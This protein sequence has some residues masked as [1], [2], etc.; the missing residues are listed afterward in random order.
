MK[1]VIFGAKCSPTLANF[2]LRK[3]AEDHVTGTTESL[4]AAKAITKN[5]YMDDFLKSEESV[6]DA[7]T[8]QREVTSLVAKG[9]FRLTKWMSNSPD[10]LRSV[11]LEERSSCE[12]D[13]SCLGQAE[14]RALG[15]FWS[16]AE[17]FLCVKSSEVD[18]TASK[19]GVLRRLSMVFDPLGIVSPFLLRAKLLVQRLWALRCGWDEPLTG[20][21]LTVWGQWLSELPL[22]RDIK[23]P[24]CLKSELPLGAAVHAVELHVFCDASENAFGAV[25]YMR[26]ITQEGEVSTSFVMSRTR[27]APLKQLT[28][29][30]LE[31]Q[32]AVLGVRLVNFIKQ[33]LSYTVSNTFYWTDSQV[34][35]KYINSESRRYQTF[36]ANRIAEIHES[37]HP[38]QWRHV[39]GHQNPA[40]VCSRG[41]S[42]AQLRADVVWRTGPD[43]LSKGPEEWPSQ[44]EEQ[45]LNSDDPEMKKPK[46][47]VFVTQTNSDRLLDP[48]RYS[49]WLRYR[50]VSAWIM[51]F[52][53]N[54][55]QTASGG[56]RVDGPLSLAEIQAAEVRILKESQNMTYKVE[57]KQIENGSSVSVEGPLAQLSPFI[58]RD[59]LLR[60]SGRL[61][62]APL[63]EASRHPVIIGRDDDITRLIISDVHQ[64]LLHG[65]LEHTLADLR[66]SYW[67]SKARLAVKTV[68][69]KCAFCRNRRANPQVPKMASLPKVR[70][71]MS[72]PF[73]CVGL[74]F[75][76]PLTVRKFRRTEKR[77]VLL[78]TCLATRAIHLELAN[79]LD[80][81][82]FL[83]AL[84]RFIARRGARP[85][86]IWSDNGTNLVA[87]EREIRESLNEWNQAQ[88]TDLLSQRQIE[89]KFLPPSGS[90]MGGVWERLVASTKRALRVALGPH[91]VTDDVLQTVL[92]EVEFVLN[93][94]PITYVSTD[95]N[96]EEPLTPNH[97]LVG[98]PEAALPPGVFAD[99]EV[100]GRKKWRNVQTLTSHFWR[101]WQKEYLPLLIKRQ[102]WL[103][104]TRK[105]QV[106]DVV[107]I[108]DG[109]SPRGYW[110]LARV[111]EVFPSSDG[112]V[113]TVE[114][115]TNGGRL[116]RRP[117]SKICFVEECPK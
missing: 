72:R 39:P 113:R 5:F 116:Y 111:T 85:R 41:A 36:V 32:A 109:A 64:R 19:R 99:H 56:E 61:Q 50:R 58:D 63:P 10:V 100:L 110:S 46:K 14:H 1:V 106:G 40:D 28:I 45:T 69:H 65:G 83:M 8:T 90:H 53:S 25:T 80:V 87:G 4:A 11:P 75:F 115:K 82:C 34:V 3:T 96:D 49:S 108:A 92:A 66:T 97:F 37:S 7:K 98:Q 29:V 27:L 47:M 26:V 57:L 52:V 62:N 21:E 71:D 105:V 59:G 16:P 17:D 104:E 79:S 12:L 48:T 103:S 15:C 73:A 91:C 78:I 89:W 6:L 43:F 77:Y 94:R 42:A 101:R 18:A 88:L 84:R 68:L 20:D 55:K 2:V 31:L 86:V 117:V 24:R 38:S 95:I 54:L 33:E 102:K 44:E 74:D 81:D 13:L 107:L 67:M 51:R 35:L 60:V 70:F 114:V 76:G 30:R 93:S 22:L 112:R 9:G 23:I